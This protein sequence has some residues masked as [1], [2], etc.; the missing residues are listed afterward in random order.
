METLEQA[1]ATLLSEAQINSDTSFEIARLCAN[2][3]RGANQHFAREIVIRIL[4]KYH[5]VPADT[6]E[7]WASVIAAA[8]LFPYLKKSGESLRDALLYEAHRSFGNSQIILHEEQRQVIDKLLGG[9]SVILA[10]PTSFG[11]SLLIDEIIAADQYR[12]IVVVQPTLALLD[13]TRKRLTKY[14]D[15]ALIVSTR[16]L[17]SDAQN[18]FLFTAERVVEYQHFPKIDFFIIDEFYKLS[19]SRDDDRSIILNQALYKL[20]GHTNNFYMLG[21]T[22]SDV[23]GNLRT[24][25]T[26]QLYK[27][28]FSTVAVDISSVGAPSRLRGKQA[29]REED[30]FE[31]LDALDQP[32][33]VYCSSPD[34]AERLAAEYARSFE[35]EDNT[36]LKSAEAEQV[37]EWIVD[38][39]HDQWA[40]VPTLKKGIAFHHGNVPRHLGSAIV[41]LFNSGFTRV[42]FCTST[43]I[44]GVNTSAKNV[45]LYD[46]KKGK[47]AIDFFDY[48]NIAGRSGRMQR[49]YV[50]RVYQFQTMP[51]QTDF[52]IDVPLFDQKNAP[53]ELLLQLRKDDLEE[54][55][56]KRIEEFCSNQDEGLINLIRQ[57]PG[58]SAAGQVALYNELHENFGRLRNLTWTGWPSYH[59]LV[60]ALELGW[61]H[62]Y[63][64]R[65][66]F[67][68]VSS[69]QQLA[70]LAREYG[71][72]KSV[73]RLIR[74]QLESE[75]SIKNYPDEMKRIQ[76]TVQRML[77]ITRR[78]F[79]FRLPKW[80][81]TISQIQAYVYKQ[82]NQTG[83]NYEYFATAIENSFANGIF[84]VLL[85]YDIPASAAQKL[86]DR[87]PTPNS[88]SE[89]IRILRNA[90]L[91][92]LGL[93]SYEQAKVREAI[94][95]G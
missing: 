6:K 39:V 73:K 22:V 83:G 63:G 84:A 43:L 35:L 8:G 66:A 32:T 92:S 5:L 95:L 31:L 28:E 91:G 17:P 21:P 13:E 4:D 89:L 57:S 72:L 85:E 10:A 1:K 62:F 67:D 27:T 78:W 71:R 7:L 54:A 15:Y 45:V 87:L 82:H 50:G 12:N 90:D 59:E 42:L 49:Y 40:L 47:K 24:K 76:V 68:G 70:L 25:T 46:N 77:M 93:S 55:S 64:K 3:L 65:D 80:L 44:E 19:I 36:K 86:Q 94:G 56:G 69:P 81:V 26:A 33:L 30:L 79:D 60:A 23:S 75:W 51:T 2:N 88:W 29:E 52:D 58:I 16:Q 9:Q 38:N 34:K 14:S 53:I 74:G 41:S 11:K 20:L 48:R 18:L 61:K 37:I